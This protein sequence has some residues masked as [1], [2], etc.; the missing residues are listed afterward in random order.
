LA[1]EERLYDELRVGLC[2]SGLTLDLVQ[3]QEEGQDTTTEDTNP[4]TGILKD[5][6]ITEPSI[7]ILEF[8]ETSCQL[9]WS[10]SSTRN[11][12]QPTGRETDDRQEQSDTH[13]DSGTD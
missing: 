6:T 8:G 10:R 1:T 2:V 12:T 11:D 13:T 9:Q 3:E 4:Q 7:G 5:M